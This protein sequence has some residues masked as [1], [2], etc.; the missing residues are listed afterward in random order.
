MIDHKVSV[1]VANGNSNLKDN[2]GLKLLES[3][4]CGFSQ[5]IP[6]LVRQ[7][8]HKLIHRARLHVCLL[9]QWVLTNP[10]L[11]K[12]YWQFWNDL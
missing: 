7:L 10:H 3:Y 1:E 2:S 9:T 6:N 5:L 12:S 11:M 8:D 4:F